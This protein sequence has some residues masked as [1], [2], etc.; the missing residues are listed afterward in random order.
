MLSESGSS[1]QAMLAAAA[2]GSILGAKDFPV[3]SPR[4]LVPADLLDLRKTLASDCTKMHASQLR[5]EHSMTQ[6][7]WS[8]RRSLGCLGPTLA[9]GRTAVGNPMQDA[10]E[11]NEIVARESAFV[12][13]ILAEVG[14]VIV[15][16][17][18]MI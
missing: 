7:T 10:L 8:S 14:K 12:D 15:G 4:D 17:T 2:F 1:S 11:L 6:S 18:Y 13:R 16:Q 5:H 9:R 3:R